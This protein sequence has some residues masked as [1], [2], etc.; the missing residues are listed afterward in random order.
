M[1]PTPCPV[2]GAPASDG[3]IT[4]RN[5]DGPEGV[6]GGHGG[7]WQ[8][9]TCDD[10]GAS[11]AECYYLLG[12]L[13]DEAPTEDGYSEAWHAG[14]GCGAPYFRVADGSLLDAA[15][16]VLASELVW[17]ECAARSGELEVADVALSD[18]IE[19]LR[20]SVS[21]FGEGP[22]MV[23]ARGVDVGTGEVRR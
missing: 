10:C 8:R 16:G 1:E 18:A 22:S 6:E 15:L 4:Y 19:V 3:T 14:P 9:A 7:V 13:V 20:A 12:A 17:R 5:T 23:K 21:A 11:W 2:C